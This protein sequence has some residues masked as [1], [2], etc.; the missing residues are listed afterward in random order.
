MED[1]GGTTPGKPGR[2]RPR[3]PDIDDDK[4]VLDESFYIPYSKPGYRRLF[5][6]KSHSQEY[7]V[8][9]ESTQTDSNIG[10][11]NP[12]TLTSIFKEEIKGITGIKRVAANKIAIAFSQASYANNYLLNETF[13]L[14]NNLKAFIP[15]RSIEKI[16]VLRYVP[17]RISNEE[18]FKKLTS[19]Y[20]II[21]VRRFTK[22]VNGKVKPFQTVSVTFLSN[23]LPQSVSLDIFNY[24]VYEY[25]PPL[26]QCYKC[27]KFN[28]HAKICKCVQKCSICSKEHHYSQCPDDQALHCANCGGPHLAISRNCPVKQK[29][30]LEKQ[31]KMTYSN[32]TKNTDHT[33]SLA[34]YSTDFPALPHKKHEITNEELIQGIIKSDNILKSLV[35]TLVNLSNSNKKMTT[36]VIKEVLLSNLKH[37]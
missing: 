8:Y 4:D 16:G 28:H 30:I 1:P 11:K 32:I 17:T 33:Y 36:S 9:T 34:H 29:K 31:N 2:K 35:A 23:I 27:F 10:N 22:K 13:H 5:P 3:G 21:G 20:E 25:N 7:I 26:L 12:L 15:A 6:E 19:A 37:G 24:K 14:K 18:L